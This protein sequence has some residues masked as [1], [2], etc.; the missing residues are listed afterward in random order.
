MKDLGER[1]RE[2]IAEAREAGRLEDLTTALREELA[3][4]RERKPAPAEDWPVSFGMIG[5]S[6][7]MQAV[8]SL[9]ERV[10]PSDVSV[11]VQG[12]T[13]TGKEL[14]ARALHTA[15]PRKAKPFIAENCA[16]VPANLLESEL[17]GHT[18]GS[19]TGAIADRDGHFVAADGGT[20]FLDEIGDMPHD[21][22]A[23]L[24]R[25]LEAGE[26]RPVGSNKTVKVDVRVVAATH[27]DLAAMV[28]EKL[29]REDLL[30]RLNVIRIQ[31]PPLRER[32]GDV[33]HLVRYFLARCAREEGKAPAEMAP[34]ALE[35]L[36]AHSWPGNVRQLENEIRR[37]TALTRGAIGLSD[38]S[39][40]IQE[41]SQS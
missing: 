39:P 21:M 10:A 22:Q 11:L 19:F 24:L 26:V 33:A 7:G 38:L 5:D 36:T 23:K 3:S 37:A 28:A 35:A 41:G 6:E 16:A 13:G 9:L 18:K 8:Y 20:L 32:N 2:L 12:A 27:R 4:P 30:Y 1:M 17:F 25:V 29:F 31:L 14:V 34:E 40:E 15:S